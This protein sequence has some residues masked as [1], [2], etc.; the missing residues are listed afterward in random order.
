MRR[1]RR[2]APPTSADQSSP[3][4]SPTAGA[5]PGTAEHDARPK[6]VAVT[7]LTYDEICLELSALT[8]TARR[9]FASEERRRVSLLSELGK[10]DDERA[11][12]MAA[13]DDADRRA[14]LRALIAAWDARCDP[15]PT[16]LEN[17]Q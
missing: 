1:R 17:D 14:E 4:T 2:T 6:R 13:A 3:G 15:T 12:A 9:L 11:A 8:S 7:D 10:R 16:Y 5:T